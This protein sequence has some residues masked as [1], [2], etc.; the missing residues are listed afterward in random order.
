MPDEK[1]EPITDMKPTPIANQATLGWDEDEPLDIDEVLDQPAADAGAP[2]D[3][4]QNQNEESQAKEPGD[5]SASPFS[6][7]EDTAL[8]PVD[9]ING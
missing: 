7:E 9:E 4:N 3:L 6:S 5:S 8:A 1:D 2:I